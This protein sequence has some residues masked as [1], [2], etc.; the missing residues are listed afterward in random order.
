MYFLK[1]Y[2]EKILDEAIDNLSLKND[3]LLIL[4]LAEKNAPDLDDLVDHLNLLEI[5]FIGGLFPGLI[6]G[7][8]KYEEGMIVMKLRL[9]KEPLLIKGL[10]SEDFVI[11]DQVDPPNSTQ[12][13]TALILLD[14][15]TANISS[16]LGRLQNKIGDRVSFIGGGAGSL[17]LEQQKCIFTKDGAFQDAALLCFIDYSINLGVHHGWKDLE[18]PFVATRVEKNKVYELNWQNAFEVYSKFVNLDSGKELASENFFSIAK[19]Y[20]FGMLKENVEDI[21]RDPIAVGEEGELICVG[22]VPE[23]SVLKILK[24]QNR[25]LVEAA[26]YA[27]DDSLRIDETNYEQ[28]FVVDCISRV[29]FLEDSFK[30]ELNILER[31]AKEKDLIIH[32]ILSLGEISSYG[33]GLLEFFNKTIV[34]GTIYNQ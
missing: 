21:V 6:F 27:I 14:G 33:D 28:I 16:F 32:G 23:N 8:E 18:G 26:R 19:G 17:S 5:N 15:L 25:D 9:A 34:V 24:G 4:Y 2:D 13:N 30:D 7:S 12:N 29:L 3:E 22:E 1:T 20:P 10:N 11:P 31:M